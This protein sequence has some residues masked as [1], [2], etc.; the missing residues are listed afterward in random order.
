MQ[1]DAGSAFDNRVTWTFDLLTSLSTPTELLLFASL[2]L[3]A[4]VVFLL[5]GGQTDRHTKS[6]MQLILL[7][8]LSYT[9]GVGNSAQCGLRTIIMICSTQC[10]V[11]GGIR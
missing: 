10:E 2:V 3:I 6:Q 5:D 4:Q 11:T 8:T 7:S 1:T 9:A